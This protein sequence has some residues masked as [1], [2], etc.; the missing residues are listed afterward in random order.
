[1][2]KKRK[3]KRVPE[4]R[5]RPLLVELRVKAGLT[6]EQLAEKLKIDKSNVSHWENGASFPKRA[7][8]PK[9]ADALG[10]TVAELLE[11]A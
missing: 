8:L 4:L 2:A 1:M 9:V 11:A 3:T 6:Q 10:V 7:R 5:P